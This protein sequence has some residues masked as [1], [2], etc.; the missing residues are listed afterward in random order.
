MEE[1]PNVLWAYRITPR[2]GTG[3]TPFCLTYGAEAVIPAEIGMPTYRISYFEEKENDE[4]LQQSLD[5]VEERR[6]I[7]A[8]REVKYKAIMAHHYNAKV[9]ESISQVYVP[10]AL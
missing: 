4:A 10:A 6:D 1:L 2:T 7:A 5:L 8:L 9:L 3:E